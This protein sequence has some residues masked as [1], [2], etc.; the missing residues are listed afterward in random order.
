VNEQRSD[1]YFNRNCS[2]CGDTEIHGTSGNDG[3]RVLAT[4]VFLPSASRSRP[5]LG[6]SMSS[7]QS[8]PRAVSTAVKRPELGVEDPP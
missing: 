5:A 2:Y 4:A 7:D 6:P 1:F 3:D 8:L